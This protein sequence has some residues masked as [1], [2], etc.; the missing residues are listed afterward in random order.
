MYVCIHTWLNTFLYFINIYMYILFYH[1]SFI[2]ANLR[3]AL[4]SLMN[5]IIGFGQNH[6]NPTIISEKKNSNAVWGQS[7]KKPKLPDKLILT[8]HRG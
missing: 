5:Q 4:K 7:F 3:L 1:R 6:K 8:P 2:F